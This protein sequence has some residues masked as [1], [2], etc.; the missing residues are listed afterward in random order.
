MNQ[1]NQTNPKTKRPVKIFQYG[2]GN[3]LRGFVEYMIQIANDKKVF[4]GNIQI[5]KATSFG[6]LELLKSQECVYTVLLRGKKDGE[7]YVEKQVITSVADTVASYEEYED[8]AAFAKSEELRFIVSN[9]TE[10]GIVYDETD[11]IAFTPPKTF[12]GKLT[13]FLYERFEYFNGAPHMGMIILPVELIENN[14]DTLKDC[15]LKYVTRW[16]LPQAFADWLNESNTFCNTLVDRIVTGYPH[17]EADDLE[18]EFGYEDKLIVAGEPFALWVIES[19]DPS[20]VAKEL[21]LNEAGLPVIFT[22]NL[23]PYRERKVRVLNGAHTSSVLAA[24]LMGLDTVGEMVKDNTMRRFLETTIYNEI[25]PMVPLPKEEVQ[26]FADYVIERF[27]NPFIQHNL[28]S[29]A[30]N[31]VSKFKARVLPTIIETEAKTGAVPP[32]LSFSLAALIS[33]YSGEK[34]DDEEDGDRFIGLRGDVQYD[35]M[36]DVSVLDFFA[37]AKGMDTEKI[38]TAFLSRTDFWG[39]DLTKIPNFPQTVTASLQSIRDLGMRDAV[40]KLLN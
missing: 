7:T 23:K 39:E 16:N 15:C 19:K 21:P 5:V 14:G 31:S 34:Y 13:K 29:I 20:A 11:E 12:P 8:Y 37:S 22:D 1:I 17:N 30:L 24:Y 4:N 10:A 36:D 25:V 33:F 6:S 40:V 28:L 2:E 26:L 32:L 27:E 35:I 9:T 18:R 38:V 3:F